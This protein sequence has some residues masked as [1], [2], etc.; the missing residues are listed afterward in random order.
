LSLTL[1]QMTLQIKD[2]GIGM[3]TTQI[4]HAFGPFTQA[5]GSDTRRQGGIGIGLALIKNYTQ[6]LGGKLS[7]ECE[8][9]KGCCFRLIFD[10]EKMD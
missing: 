2:T 7:T 6:A 9:N 4:K 1:Q 5:D 3:T 10:L 8:V